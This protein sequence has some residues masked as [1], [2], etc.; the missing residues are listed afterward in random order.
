MI[1]RARPLAVMCGALVAVLAGVTARPAWA[2]YNYSS[3]VT[4][5]GAAAYWRLA[6]ASG[7]TTLADSSGNA[8]TANVVGGGTWATT[9]GLIAGDTNGA[10]LYGPST[11]AYGQYPDSGNALNFTATV[12]VEAWISTSTT[13][14]QGILEKGGNGACGF[15]LRIAGG[16]LTAFVGNGG[17]SSIADPATITTNTTHHVVEV[18][19]G[20]TLRL[21][22]DGAQVASAAT[23]HPCSS[24]G[25]S[26]LIG[27]DIGTN[28]Y[29]GVLDEVAIYGAA[30][31]AA[32]VSAHYAN[33]I[34]PT[35]A[36][37]T[38]TT[39]AAPT[40]TTTAAPTTTTTAAPTTTTTAAPT[41]T[42]TAAGPMVTTPADR[43]G[44]SMTGSI[45]G[46]AATVVTYLLVPALGIFVLVRFVTWAAR[47]A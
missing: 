3:V 29:R 34:D 13:A 14:D 15:L 4:G 28:I 7:A 18:Y 2:A 9:A 26:V 20:T 17:W 37:T 23:A 32:Q 31:T 5:D 21:Y 38:T 39:T 45:T 41:T 6:D 47:E 36:P 27:H 10:G 25:V 46:F 1:R 40:T 8:R 42:T 22:K 44:G 16:K 19:D 30:L 43:Q 33:G 35:T 24:A 12:T 11:L